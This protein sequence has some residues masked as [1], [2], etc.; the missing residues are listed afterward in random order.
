MLKSSLMVAYL[1]AMQDAILDFPDS[2][3]ARI[4]ALNGV[5]LV[6]K[7]STVQLDNQVDQQYPFLLLLSLPLSLLQDIFPH[8]S[9]LFRLEHAERVTLD[10]A[11][12]SEDLAGV[13][14]ELEAENSDEE[15]LQIT[16]LVVGI[17]GTGKSASINSLLGYDAVSADAFDG[18]KKVKISTLLKV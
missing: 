17:T 14:R 1:R 18:T 11:G 13:V 8:F 2:C 4:E 9:C 16:A 7:S 12:G 5:Q 15:L 6:L 3:N 10:Q